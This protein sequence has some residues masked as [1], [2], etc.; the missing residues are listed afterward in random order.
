VIRSRLASILLGVLAAAL[1]F[2]QP[3]T[4]AHR[5]VQLRVGVLLTEP[6]LPGG[7]LGN[8]V[9]HAW[10][11]LD[12]DT[13]V[14]PREWNLVNPIA[15]TTLT[16]GLRDRWAVNVEHFGGPGGVPAAGTRIDKR[17]GAYWEVP[18]EATGDDALAR[19]DVLLMPV[20]SMLSLNPLARERLR[21]F[22]DQGGVLWVDVLGGDTDE[23]NPAPLPFALAGGPINP[24]LDQSHPLV[25]TPHLLTIDDMVLASLAGFGTAV[26]PSASAQFARIQSWIVNADWRLTDFAKLRPIY[27]T[28]LDAWHVAAGQVGDGWMVVTTGATS[29]VLN[30]GAGGDPNLGYRS[31]GPANDA[32]SAV[33]AK[34][35]VN[36]VNLASGFTTTAG[37]SRRTGARPVDLQPPLF[38]RFAFDG[39][40]TGQPV[41]YNGRL[42]LTGGGR[43]YVLDANPGADLDGDGNPDDGLAD[44]LAAG[45]D[46]IWVSRSLGGI[47]PPTVAE[48]PSSEVR[49]QIVVVDGGGTLHVFPLDAAGDDVPPV[50]SAAPPS[51]P[52]GVPGGPYAPVV[53]E[54][55]AYVTDA[56]VAMAGHVLGRVW[57]A[58]LGRVRFA[59]SPEL[60]VFT[61][62]RAWRIENA[63]RFS[64]PAAGA[65]IGY[66]P[67][68]DA[69]GALD[70]VAYVPLRANGTDRPAGFVSLWLGSRGEVPVDVTATG[71]TLLVTTRAA[72]NNLP[73]YLPD[74]VPNNTQ[75]L[76]LKLSVIDPDTGRPFPTALV[77]SLFT[78][79][80]AEMS[81]GQF[82]VQ[83]TAAGAARVWEGPGQNA[84]LRVDYTIDMGAPPTTTPSEAFVRGDLLFADDASFGRQIR[85]Q[86]ALSSHGNLFVVTGREGTGIGGSLYALKEEGRG[87]FRLLYRWDLHE[88]LRFSVNLAG[89]N[90]QTIEYAPAIVDYDGI[91]GFPGIGGF[92]DVQLQ[93]M[94]FVSGPTVRGD[95]VFVAATSG[96][97]GFLTPAGQI[98]TVLMA[99]EA[100]PA[101]AEFIVD[102][103]P[104][105]FALVQPDV[106]RSSN[107][108]Q[109]EV[110]SALQPGQFHVENM[111]GV[112]DR[113]KVRVDNMMTVRRGR[114]RDS[115]SAN[116]PVILRQG[117]QPD[118]VVEPEA[119]EPDG[120][121]VPGLAGG[122]W[123][124]LRWY[125]VFNGFVATAQPVVT[126][127]MLYIGGASYLPSMLEGDFPPR[128]TRGLIYGIDT[129]VAPGDLRS[130]NFQRP[131]MAAQGISP[132]P[133]QQYLSQIE[134]LAGEVRPSPYFLWPQNTGVVS[135]ADFRLRVRQATLEEPAVTGLVA[136]QGTLAAWAGGRLY[137]FQR[138][139]FLVA[140]EGRIGRFDAS[141]N[142]VW[143]TESTFSAGRERPVG[144]AGRAVQL[145]QPNRVYPAGDSA[146]WVVDTGNDRIMRVDA[147]GRE[148]RTITRFKVD[149]NHAPMGLPQNAA[150]S[151]RLPR[152]VLTYTTIVPR[153]SNPFTNAQPTELWQ[154]YLI[155]DSGNFRVIELVDRYAFDPNTGANLGVVVYND[156]DSTAPGGNER[157]LGVLLWH[158]RPEL[159]GKQFAYNSIDRAFVPDPSGT[160]RIPI[161]AFGFGNLEP[162]L[163]TFG[164]DTGPAPDLD[165]SSGSGGIVLYN[166]ADGRSEV[167]T[168]FSVRA[169]PRMWNPETNDWTLARPANPEQR[170]QGLTSVSLRYTSGGA[171]WPSVMLTDVAGVWEIE[172]AGGSWS[173]RWA[174]PNEAYRVM[175]RFTAGP[176]AGLPSPR[177]PHNLRAT[178]ARR[179]DSGEV[180]VT[181][182]Y[183]GRTRGGEPFGGEVV[184]LYGG[185]GGGGA[186]RGFDWSLPN[187]G[188]DSFMVN[189]EL[190]PVT[191]ARGLVAPQFAA[192]R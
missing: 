94:R 2:G 107:Q 47:S 36:I 66:I 166:P 108:S 178:Y 30:R 160:A 88:R 53:H 112:T 28:G 27:F 3:Q 43:V 190:P 63:G 116:M 162:G 16:P 29:A 26:P 4:F 149:P 55:V 118:A 133:W 40:P 95:T 164:L 71:A 182:A 191:G 41:L 169:M 180:I 163:S 59:G 10:G 74:P 134:W 186:E 46:V 64:Q 137:G 51:A 155:A 173:V 177:N 38:R 104:G 127:A 52:A 145:S 187:L 130:P 123:S 42:I 115:I 100:D 7:E 8:P 44:P 96:K 103:I 148:L 67:V 76:G 68:A 185:E 176:N 33:A 136:G 183:F 142:P 82:Q 1:V 98:C 140:D 93:N 146:F 49:A 192:R 97:G 150:R 11:Q 78:G 113:R 156:P 157:A 141:G 81:P 119:T 14:K 101:P 31:A 13:T 58:D 56:T 37:G 120:L 50:A 92:M 85:G 165:R 181:N 21:R 170:I 175:R 135:F 24:V 91:L 75:R 132:R 188:F 121:M 61:G 87:E 6:L 109:P 151:L 143:T 15:P 179:L 83:M 153:A 159:A 73:V 77:N 161:L 106:T 138:A 99:F 54:G 20:D 34:L 114:V 144:A 48:V 79:A 184:L 22:I 152:D 57:A 189:F 139:D 158:I 147:A 90:P 125:T 117:G 17:H 131:W 5:S 154:H 124:P 35:A 60:K 84:S 62:G 129:N 32:F 110:H 89:G 70:R 80:I 12:R 171:T 9:P 65:T 25:T 72:L 102:G 128:F 69:S 174:L 122:R 45:A 105:N 19:F 86:I 18:L 39:A 126:G 111:D 23:L 168:R 167:I 172:G